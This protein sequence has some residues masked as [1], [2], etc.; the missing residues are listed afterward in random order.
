MSEDTEHSSAN[1]NHWGPPLWKFLHAMA[2]NYPQDP[3][4]QCKASCRQFFYALR[5]LLPC[6]VCQSHYSSFLS[7]RQ[8][9]TGSSLALQE[10]VLWLH[11]E[12]SQRVHPERQSWTLDQLEASLNQQTAADATV[13]TVVSSP[14]THAL[15]VKTILKPLEELQTMLF[16]G[17]NQ[18]RAWSPRSKTL[19]MSLTSAKQLHSKLSEARRD[20]GDMSPRRM[21]SPHVSKPLK[22]SQRTHPRQSNVQRKTMVKQKQSIIFNNRSNRSF[23]VRTP[24]VTSIKP[25]MSSVNTTA[26]ANTTATTATTNTTAN[27]GPNATAEA[28]KD[29]GCGKK[30]KK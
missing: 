16:D 11:N 2:K 4:P 13:A 30:K 20:P 17:S 6:D 27:C 9:Q 10:W 14:P 12:V 1:P 21:A 5:H 15:Q 28:K 22:H 7:Q 8:P 18:Q 26:A 23:R 19:S 3:S 24:L 29:C 25:K